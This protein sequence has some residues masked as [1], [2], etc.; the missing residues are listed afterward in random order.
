MRFMDL[1]AE[2]RRQFRWRSWN[3]IFEKLPL[4][5]GQ[6]VLDLGCGIGDQARELASLGCQVIGLDG[7]DE[8]IAAAT[9]DQPSNCEFVCCDL[10]SPPNI[11]A[12]IDGIWCSFVAAYFTNL[13]ELLKRWTPLLR[14]GGWLAIT[15]IDDLFR[16]E[17]LSERTQWLLQSLVD[18]ALATELYDFCMGRKLR[19]FVEQ[20]GFTTS[21]VL[22]LPDQELSFQGSAIPEV[23]DAWRNR[24]QRLP[25][26]RTICGSEFPNVQEEFLSCLSRP[27]HASSAKVISCIAVKTS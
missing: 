13:P 3:L 15:E 6:K 9:L 7:N 20:A 23:V 12:G 18:D 19:D 2:Y 10:R 11:S 22:T 27:D 21:L 17:P 24:F 25:H 4:Q 8:L 5:Q 16:H 14:S 26:L 1:V